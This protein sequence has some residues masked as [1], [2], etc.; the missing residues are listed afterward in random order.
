MGKLLW[1]GNTL[2]KNTQSKEEAIVLASGDTTLPPGQV[3]NIYLYDF[4]FN[5][6]LVWRLRR[7]GTL[8]PLNFNDR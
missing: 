2:F 8:N 1:V 7:E 5:G 4:S 3:K 6:A